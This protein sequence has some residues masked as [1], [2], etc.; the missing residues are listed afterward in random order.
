MNLEYPTSLQSCT[1]LLYT[2]S[3]GDLYEAIKADS[4]P[5][6]TRDTTHIIAQ[7]MDAV[8]FV[9]DKGIYHRDIKPENILIA[10]SDW[11]IKLTDWGLATTEQKS[12]ER[13][14]GSER[15]MA[16]ELFEKMCIRDRYRSRSNKG[17]SSL[18]RFIFY[19]IVRL[20]NW[21]VDF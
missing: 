3:G 12:L 19:S 6:K 9:H 4:I 8:Q 14:V 5:R 15:Y 1:C 11:T 18:F 13:N 7:I 21:C 20:S 17:V 10:G 2:S 16:P